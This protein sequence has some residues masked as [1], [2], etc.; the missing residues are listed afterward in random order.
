MFHSYIPVLLI[1]STLLPCGFDHEAHCIIQ[2]QI[3]PQALHY[4]VLHKVPSRHQ[5]N[6]PADQST[7]TPRAASTPTSAPQHRHGRPN[8]LKIQKPNARDLST[9]DTLVA[10]NL[11]LLCSFNISIDVSHGARRRLIHGRCRSAG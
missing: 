6:T 9:M 4:S 2:S 10:T 7:S 8:T 11:D 5:V 3:D 1:L